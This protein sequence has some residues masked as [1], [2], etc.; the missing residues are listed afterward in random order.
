MEQKQA[1]EAQSETKFEAQSETKAKNAMS[2][3]QDYA[4]R[5]A[6][7]APPHPEDEFFKSTWNLP[8]PSVEKCN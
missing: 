3:F 8:L 7:G 2:A 4:R 5:R 1:I 6:T